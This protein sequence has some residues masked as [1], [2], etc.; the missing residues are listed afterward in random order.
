MTFKELK[1][2][3]KLEI[4]SIGISYKC[5]GFKERVRIERCL[6]LSLKH[7][8][9]NTTQTSIKSFNSEVIQ[10]IK[11]DTSDKEL[12]ILI[13]QIY[14]FKVFVKSLSSD[15]A[16]ITGDTL[17]KTNLG[18]EEILAFLNNQSDNI[19]EKIENKCRTTKD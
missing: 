8:C 19:L 3:F 5:F 1:K 7:L 17:S 4:E 10:K 14:E 16:Y 12:S 2:F 6:F 15:S 9:K 18:T 11:K 13:D